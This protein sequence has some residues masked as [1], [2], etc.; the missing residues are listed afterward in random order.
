MEDFCNLIIKKLRQDGQ[1]KKTGLYIHYPFCR[2]KCSYCHFVS[3]VFE[4]DGHRRWLLAAKDEIRRLARAFNEHLLI[5]TVY[6]GGG[7][8][9]LLAPDEVAYLLASV[10]QSFETEIQEV[11]LEVNPTAE[12]ERIKG[13]LQA[14]VSRLS[15]GVQ[16]FDPAVLGI[17]GRDYSPEQAMR[18]L[19]EAGRAGV[20]NAGLD[21]MAGIP[22]ESDLTLEVNLKAL[23]ETGPKHI[24]VYLLEELENVP[25]GKVWNKAALSEEA[26][27]RTY[28][29]F[30]L[31]LEEAGW[32]QY[33]IS[34]FSQPGYQCRHNLKYWRYQPF[35]GVGPSASSHLGNFRWTNPTGLN[36]W[37]AALTS[38]R[39]AFSEFIELSPEEEEREYLAA[40][41]RLKEGIPLDELRLRFPGLDFPVFEMKVRELEAL[42]LLRTENGRVMIPPD[43]FLISNSIICELI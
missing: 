13:W 42:G 9:S 8:P 40:W 2:Q 41:L 25:F 31:K 15:F 24:S 21:L 16:S 35:L 11:S 36:D 6:I 37:L 27:V 7:T 19:E 20:E 43:K 39:G 1:K 18:L 33:E 4:P 3:S 12:P 22:G 28:E 5:D 17:L 10:Q 34:N 38:G 30:R 14:G 32:L 29:A 26:V 23:L